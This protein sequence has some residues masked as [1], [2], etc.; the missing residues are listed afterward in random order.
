MFSLAIFFAFVAVSLF[1]DSALSKAVFAHYMVWKDS[2]PLKDV[3]SSC[4][5]HGQIV[6]PITEAHAHQDVDDAMAMK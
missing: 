6:G 1:T 4:S 3:Y 2:K 5:L